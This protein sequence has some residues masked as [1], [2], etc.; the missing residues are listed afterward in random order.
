ML[1]TGSIFCRTHTGPSASV[2]LSFYH[3]IICTRIH[4][5][6]IYQIGIGHPLKQ[7]GAFFGAEVFAFA[8]IFQVMGNGINK[9]KCVKL[10]LGYFIW[11]VVTPQDGGLF[12]P[13]SELPLGIDK[14]KI[15]AYLF[16]RKSYRM[17]LELDAE[18]T[19]RL[20]CRKG[21]AGTVTVTLNM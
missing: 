13:E 3:P 11:L 19:D 18:F 2:I 12:Q 14:V 10:V 6:R 8:Q 17:N 20:C 9:G 1:Y 7:V 4:R 21:K 5:L 16:S 15:F